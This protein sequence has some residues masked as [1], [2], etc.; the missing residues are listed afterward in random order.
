MGT[1]SLEGM[2]FYARHGYYEEERIIGN[3]YSVDI[4]IELDF[5]LAAESDKLEGT[6]NYERIYAIIAD[7]M[8]IDAL[9]L[10]HLAHKI[11]Q[12]VK[13][14]YPK[15]SKV[16]VKVSKHNPPIRGLCQRASVMLSA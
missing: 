1:V 14:E 11:I 13:K 4:H 12:S 9:L 2:E 6:V 15:I 3:K 8:S 5:D 7:V 10:E 16:T